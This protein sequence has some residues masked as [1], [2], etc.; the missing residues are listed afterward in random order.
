MTQTLRL[1]ARRWPQ[2][3]AWFLAG[4]LARYLLIELAALVGSRW[5]LG[6]LLIM[7]LA[8]LARL[9]S[10]VGM[11]LVL[12]DDMPN[13]RAAAADPLPQSPR[14]RRRA[15]VDA[16]LISILP[17]FAFYYA[18]GLLAADMR[19]YALRALETYLDTTDLTDPQVVSFSEIDTLSVDALTIGVIVAAFAGRWV[20]KR[21][22]AKLPAWTTL[23]GVY[24]EAIWVFLTVYLI[25]GLF[26]GVTAW[27]QNRQGAVWLADAREWLGQFARPLA[28]V[29]DAIGWVVAEVGA[30]VL[31]PLAWLTIAGVIYGRAIAARTVAV[32]ANERVDAVR[33]RYGTVPQ[34]VRR[35]L[36][37]VWSART[38]R[39]R[40]VV[41]AVATIW[42]AGA[43][44][45]GVFILGYTVVMALEGWLRWAIV[46]ALGP[47][48]LSAFWMV[49]D[50]ALIVAV[51]AV[52]EPLRVSVVAAAYDHAL[53]R[54]SAQE[55]HRLEEPVDD[56]A[57]AEAPTEQGQ[58]AEGAAAGS[59]ASASIANDR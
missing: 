40:A 43:V 7:A 54:L 35:R 3:L 8:I 38:G 6:G 37:D 9:I 24:L 39:V 31:E 29:W 53:P 16:V 42:H 10:F 14:Q 19:N 13:L 45:M 52:V 46:A 51:V 48:D 26:G 57:G 22:R 28:W 47:H 34:L 17:F 59:S 36:N 21:W 33:R 20:L 1:A 23:V 44:P 58:P 4:W 41:N 11:F 18:W 32:P 50:T 25:S 2:L 56:A 27:L 49:I 12:R 30:I 55:L 5:L 15:F